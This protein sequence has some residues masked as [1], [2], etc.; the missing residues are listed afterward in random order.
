[1]IA[2]GMVL[3]LLAIDI[4]VILICARGPKASE[5]EYGTYNNGR[6]G[7]RHKKTGAVQFILWKAG[8]QG[9]AE[10][11]WHDTDSFW[12]PTFIPDKA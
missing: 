5:W 9:H 10:D 4:A 2:I 1:M 6:P 11:F 8:E 7:R 3:G 12:W